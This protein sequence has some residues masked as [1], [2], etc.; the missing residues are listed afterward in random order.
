MFVPETIS[1]EGHAWAQ[2]ICLGEISQECGD[3]HRRVIYK[4]YQQVLLDPCPA[5]KYQN[6][7]PEWYYHNCGASASTSTAGTSQS[8]TSAI[9][10][11]VTIEGIDQKSLS[12]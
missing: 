11:V 10:V 8:G 1:V 12:I 9:M 2:Y 7:L 5:L 3:L 6:I 4:V